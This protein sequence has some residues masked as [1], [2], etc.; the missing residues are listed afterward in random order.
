MSSVQNQLYARPYAEAAFQYAKQHNAVLPWG[1]FFTL[2]S[3]IFTD[4]T[5]QNLLRNPLVSQTELVTAM[6]SPV[7]NE[8]DSHQTNF[9]LLLANNRRLIYL[10]AIADQ[11]NT[12]R[13]QDESILR[14]TVSSAFALDE[15]TQAR[16]KQKLMDQFKKQIIME[17][18]ISPEL[19]GGLKIQV[20]DRVLDSSIQDRLSQLTQSLSRSD[21][22]RT[23]LNQG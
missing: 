4:P 22:F 10:A 15:A 19:I 20:G 11:F 3:K 1:D 18:K 6:T 2:F 14:V 16:L 17:T 23:T 5:L 12:L 9:L 21:R 13:D 7:T 8:L